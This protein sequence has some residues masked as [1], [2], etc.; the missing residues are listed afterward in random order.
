MTEFALET[1]PTPL[2]DVMVVRRGAVVVALDWADCRD[3]LDGL[4][5]RRF[6]EVSLV[7]GPQSEAGQAVLAYFGG[8]PT[9]LD[10][11]Q[12]DPGGTEFQAEVWRHLRSIPP[13]SSSTYSAIATALGRP[14]AERAVGAA[15]GAN[16]ISLILPCHRVIGADGELRGYAGGVSRKRWLLRFEGSPV[17]AEQAS[18]FG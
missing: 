6:G 1:V 5:A 4:L 12:V 11:V 14:G 15:N 7:S 9:A 16:P 8:Q 18:L 13:G 17:P 3:R 2:G 10:G